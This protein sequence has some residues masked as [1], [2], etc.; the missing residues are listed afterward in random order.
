MV[1]YALLVD[2][3]LPQL[4]HRGGPWPERTPRNDVDDKQHGV[5]WLRDLLL[6]GLPNARICSW[7]YDAS[8]HSHMSL[9]SHA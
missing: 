4:E 7:G 8:T 9:Y 6:L 2:R 1:E 3:Q 5:N